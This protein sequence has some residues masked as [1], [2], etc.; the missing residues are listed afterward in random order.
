MEAPDAEDEKGGSGLKAAAE[1]GA[2]GKGEAGVGKGGDA[3]EE[4][5]GEEGDGDGDGDGDGGDGLPSLYVG[6]R[7]RYRSVLL[8]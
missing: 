1:R 8:R 3:D 2:L 7:I 4:G 5:G 6:R